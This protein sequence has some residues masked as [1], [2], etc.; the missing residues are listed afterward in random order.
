VRV[1]VLRCRALFALA[2]AGVW[3]CS[4]PSGAADDADRCVNATGREAIAACQSLSE[5]RAEAVK[6]FLA[7]QFKLSP[8]NM[9][10]LG[11]GRSQ[12]KNAA[13]PLAA[14]NRRVQIVN[15]GEQAAVSRKRNKSR[16][17]RCGRLPR[18]CTSSQK[19]AMQ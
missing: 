8:D 12:L 6:L 3:G 2:L 13:E 10:A 1:A 15:T 5:R 7:Q 17:D 18:E 9:L 14:E 19:T 16:G 11:F 4:T